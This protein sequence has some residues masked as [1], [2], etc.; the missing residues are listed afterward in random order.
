MDVNLN[1]YTCINLDKDTPYK[2]LNQFFSAFPEINLSNLHGR[3]VL[4]HWDGMEVGSC[5]HNNDKL[6]MK[7]I[8]DDDYCDL[9]FPRAYALFKYYDQ[10]K[11]YVWEDIV[12]WCWEY[13]KKT[14][15]Y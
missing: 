3:E 9:R 11:I 13:V 7:H 1:H 15:Q 4:Y 6:F 2:N 12:G 10:P 14:G 8:E 5:Y